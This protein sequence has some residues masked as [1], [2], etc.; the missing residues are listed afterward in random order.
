MTSLNLG[1]IS[2]VRNVEILLIRH[3]RTTKPPVKS[4]IASPISLMEAEEVWS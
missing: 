4:G 2:A 3:Y 1:T